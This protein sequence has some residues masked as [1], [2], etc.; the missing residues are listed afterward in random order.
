M[1][2]TADEVLNAY[3]K[4]PTA[5]Q[6]SLSE[7]KAVDFI[8]QL[9][10]R[11]GLHIDTVGIVT[12][13]VRDLMLGFQT[14]EEFYQELRTAVKDDVLARKIVD[15]LNKDV[16]APLREEMRKNDGSPVPANTQ[17]ATG[18]GAE[19]K[20]I[21]VTD[22]RNISAQ[23]PTAPIQ[24]KVPERVPVPIY[25]PLPAPNP[26]P[27]PATRPI[28]RPQAKVVPPPPNLPGQ[29]PEPS[30]R[31]T[32]PPRIEV[33]TPPV[34]PK[35]V[36]KPI[37]QTEAPKADPN[38]RVIHTMARDMQA[39]KSGADPFRVAHPAPPAWA[40]TATKPVA[41]VPTPSAAPSVVAAPQPASAHEPVT[42]Q[43]HEPLRAHL[44]QYGVDPYR[45]PVE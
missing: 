28:E 38:T 33:S 4:A 18:Q 13:M 43:P 17:T 8:M 41:T 19:A 1:V 30:V 32:P 40:E 2:R 29:L 15:A 12:G 25:S 44:K 6:Y 3:D 24:A 22:T 35:P 11:F 45:E 27:A 10:E 5:V 34:T 20:K 36:E 26:H 9:R 31:P 23:K 42:P 7:G 16:F 21:V 37:Q 14:P 39:L